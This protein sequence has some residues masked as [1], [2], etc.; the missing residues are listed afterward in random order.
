MTPEGKV[1][2]QVKRVLKPYRDSDELYYWMPVPSGYGDAMLDFVGSHLGRFFAIE[3][4]APGKEPTDR[5]KLTI[6]FMR[7]SGA[8]VFVI[9]GDTKELEAWLGAV[10]SKTSR[11]REVVRVE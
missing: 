9:D 11:M 1:K 6:E 8:K 2:A 3:T 5:Q 7:R 10:L 4:K